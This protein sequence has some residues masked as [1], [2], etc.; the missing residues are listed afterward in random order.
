MLRPAQACCQHMDMAIPGLVHSL[1]IL[2]EVHFMDALVIQAR[3]KRRDVHWFRHPRH[4]FRHVEGLRRKHRP[5]YRERQIKRIVRDA[6]QIAGVS[7]TNFRLLR[8]SDGLIKF[9]WNWGTWM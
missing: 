3:Y 4:L 6:F 2:Y 9:D 7:L 8:R 5:K 1:G